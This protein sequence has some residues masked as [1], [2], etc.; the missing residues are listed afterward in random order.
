MYSPVVAVLE[1]AILTFLSRVKQRILELCD[2][3]KAFEFLEDIHSKHPTKLSMDME[4]RRSFFRLWNAYFDEGSFHSMEGNVESPT[5]RASIAPIS[6]PASDTKSKNTVED[7]KSVGLPFVDRFDNNVDQT[8]R[9]QESFEQEVSHLLEILNFTDPRYA[10]DFK[11]CSEGEF[12]KAVSLSHSLLAL[13]SLLERR[14]KP[15]QSSW[16]HTVI[17][18]RSLRDSIKNIR[19]HG[20]RLAKFCRIEVLLQ[21]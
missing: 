17:A 14:L 18:P 1:H 21:M 8:Q 13:S 20:F 19:L 15:R 9:E 5:G 7:E 4:A 16:G 6:P 11:L 2:G 3:K 10:D 12:S